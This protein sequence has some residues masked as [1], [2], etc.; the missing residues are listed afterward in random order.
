MITLLTVLHV[1][2][3]V[4]LIAIVLLQ[5][6]KGADIGAS[7]GGGSSQTVFGS[8]GPLPLLNKV[9]TTSAIVFMVTSVALAYN[10]AH[11]SKSS[12]MQ[13]VTAPISQP[14]ANTTPISIPLPATNQASKSAAS[15]KANAEFPGK[16][17]T[18]SH[19]SKMP[20]GKKTK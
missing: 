9:T 12:V 20:A 15:G 5:H 7:F 16:I 1:S 4:F 8:D 19:D 18:P 17:M 6:G 13:G 14:A 3:C 10:S 11:M 2:V